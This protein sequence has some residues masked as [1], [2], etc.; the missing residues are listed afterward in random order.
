M[1]SHMG[2]WATPG[3][4]LLREIGEINRERRDLGH[5]LQPALAQKLAQALARELAQALARE[6]AQEQVPSAALALEVMQSATLAKETAVVL[7]Q[8]W[9]TRPMISP[10]R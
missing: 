2:P 10:Y 3:L 8:V 4:L 7:S 1:Y 6:L 5:H 9:A